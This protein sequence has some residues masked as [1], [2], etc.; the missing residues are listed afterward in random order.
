MIMS[1]E[2]EVK[3]K[4]DNPRLLRKKIKEVGG[5]FIEKHKEINHIFDS[6]HKKIYPKLTLRIRKIGKNAILTF[7]GP[8]KKSKMKIR[9]EI[10]IGTEDY[11]NLKKI[12]ER[13]GFFQIFRYDKFREVYKVRGIEVTIDKLAK[14]GYFCEIE[15]KTQKKILEVAK[16]LGLSKKVTNR[17]LRY[18]FKEYEKKNKVKI[19]NWVF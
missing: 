10:E 16:L 1:Y 3:A 4:I 15:G 8:K 17:S 13:L 14:I 2:I 7:K 19:K 5:K 11:K 6:K 12:F 9:E 18:Y